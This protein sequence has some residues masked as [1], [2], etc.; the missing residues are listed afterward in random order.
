MMIIQVNKPLSIQ[1]SGTKGEEIEV[2]PEDR[3]SLDVSGVEFEH[4][5]SGKRRFIPWAQIKEIYQPLD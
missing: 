3:V 5:A 4:R 2:A 1:L